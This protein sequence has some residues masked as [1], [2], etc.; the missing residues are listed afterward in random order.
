VRR[1]PGHSILSVS[2]I[3][4]EESAARSNAPVAKAQPRL[5]SRNTTGLDWH[6]LLDWRLSDVL[7]Y[8]DERNWPLHDAY[9][10]YGC[11]RVSCVFCVLASQADLLAASRCEDNIDVYRKLVRLETNSTFLVRGA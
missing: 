6:P 4:R 7:S 8:L 2:G 3:R 1:F 11:S 10:R 5:S 9:T